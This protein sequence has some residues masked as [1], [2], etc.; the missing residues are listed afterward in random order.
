MDRNNFF[1]RRSLSRM[2]NYWASTA[3]MVYWV[4]N[5]LTV[6]KQELWMGQCTCWLPMNLAIVSL[7]R[8]TRVYRPMGRAGFPLDDRAV[9]TT[10]SRSFVL[11]FSLEHDSSSEGSVLGASEKAEFSDS[12]GP[13]G[14]F[15]WRTWLWRWVS[16]CVC[17]AAASSSSESVAGV[18]QGALDVA[19]HL[20][21][22][23]KED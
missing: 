12:P 21:V 8:I 19:F 14:L 9:P 10:S 6:P 2:L 5:S 11:P 23:K 4:N 20:K 15:R 7:R 16:L 17:G 18:E 13:L 22:K 3:V 1:C